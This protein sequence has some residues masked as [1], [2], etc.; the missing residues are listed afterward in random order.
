MYRT[1][2]KYCS[3]ENRGELE[4]SGTSILLF[5]LIRLLVS[6]CRMVEYSYTL[7]D[8]CLEN[9]CKA[10]SLPVPI[11]RRKLI[12]LVV[13]NRYDLRYT[14]GQQHRFDSALNNNIPRAQSCRKLNHRLLVQVVGWAA[15][16]NDIN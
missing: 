5:G 3:V 6:F 10:K 16:L 13:R 7:P 9:V 15:H 2:V 12:C 8:N 11:S 4:Y 1:V 14:P